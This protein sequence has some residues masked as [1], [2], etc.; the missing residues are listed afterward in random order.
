[1]LRGIL[2]GEVQ[3]AEAARIVEA[4]AHARVQPQIEL[5][6]LEA[7][8][9]LRQQ[10]QAAGHAQVQNQRAALQSQQQIFRAPL[11]GH[12]LLIE[13]L[14]WHGGIDRPAQAMIVD[15]QLD[16]RRSCAARSMP[17]RVVSTSGNSG[18]QRILHSNKKP[19]SRRVC[20]VRPV[21]C[22]GAI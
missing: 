6:V 1:V 4:Q 3:A 11:D 9:V 2:A 8:G 5:V 17:R 14:R 16:A 22:A 21:S 10:A 18:M 13:H 20:S 15:A 12:D 7:R 19:A